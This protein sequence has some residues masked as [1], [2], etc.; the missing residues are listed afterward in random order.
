MW[1]CW[2]WINF[3]FFASAFDTDD[4]FH[5]ILTM[6]QMVGVVIIALG[7]PDVFASIDH[8]ETLDIRIMALGYVIM[9]I[10]MVAMWWRVARQDAENRRTAIIYI[11]FTAGAQI[12]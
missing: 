11:V 10:A 5:R 6:V 1:V 3:T 8:G 12:G 4:W 7:I 2:V 9:R